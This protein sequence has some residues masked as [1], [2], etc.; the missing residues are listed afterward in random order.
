MKTFHE[1]PQSRIR[2]RTLSTEPSSETPSEGTAD[3]TYSLKS[4]D[5][6]LQT[7]GVDDTINRPN[8]RQ[9][10]SNL[11]GRIFSG[12]QHPEDLPPRFHNL[13]LQRLDE[14]PLQVS[15]LV[16]RKV[17]ASIILVYCLVWIL[18]LRSILY[19]YLSEA[20]Y[21]SSEETPILSFSCGKEDSIWQGGNDKCGL[22]GQDCRHK[23]NDEIIIRCP[24]LCDIGS[25]SYAAID[26]GDESIKY[27]NF[28]VGGGKDEDYG[29]DTTLPYRSDSFPCGAAVH[30]G[31]ISP[32][33]GGCARL[34]F[35][36]PQ[37]GFTE[38]ASA[39]S[40]MGDSIEFDSFFPDSF[41]FIPNTD[42]QCKH[43]RD[44]RVAVTIINIILGLPLIY[45][46]INGQV[47]FWFTCITGFWTIV[48]T[49]DPPIL[50]DPSDPVNLPEL[51]SLGLER[52]LPLCFM[53]L[54]IWKFISITT[55]S[56][57]SSQ[58]GKS[59]IWYPLFWVGMLN[60]V[61]FD[62]LP[63]DRLTMSDIRA[64]PGA[65]TT[66]IILL[67]FTILCVFLQGYQLWK[68]GRIRT[69][70]IGYPLL[71]AFLLF[72]SKIPG[73]QLR[74]HHY[75]IGLIFLPGTRTKG[76]TAY[77]FQGVLLGL[78]VNGVARWGFASIAETDESLFRDDSAG[79]ID[80][81]IFS[82]YTKENT[83]VSWYEDNEIQ[84][85][86]NPAT[87]AV[88]YSLLINDIET[89]RGPNSTVSIDRLAE[90]DA[91]FGSL[92][93]S[94]LKYNEGE[95]KLYLRVSRLGRKDEKR[96]AYSK[97]LVV[98]YVSGNELTGE[99]LGESDYRG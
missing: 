84:A 83:S 33:F 21:L 86:T 36:G 75:I 59:L 30:A 26:V 95:V 46:S 34:Q 37:Y 24:A 10:H 74:I 99:L 62:R 78:L 16:S 19:P 81:P 68:A 98:N 80:A 27:R 42:G 49:F 20:P 63:V 48:L 18:C 28:Y 38:A 97:A 73:L 71:T 87:S 79:R 90:S 58:I 23:I 15:R 61:T 7:W 44:P 40:S 50:I 51:I 13:F 11:I 22:D 82:A 67:L 69:Y 4:E 25:K 66:A 60:N 72:L 6:E 64:M 96:S 35:L 89:Y 92:L 12:P 3:P 5:I 94:S 31:L 77:L 70:L 76:M 29:R 2:S 56:Q 93:S 17:K 1:N 32:T 41:R 47:A 91:E 85:D 53:L 14:L 43:C 54:V 45:L 9:R 39:H 8:N 88:F 52:F 65:I 57:P 55:L